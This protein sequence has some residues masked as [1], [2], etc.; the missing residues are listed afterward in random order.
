MLSDLIDELIEIH[1]DIGD[2]PVVTA[3][4]EFEVP[5]SEVFLEVLEIDQGSIYLES[6]E[7]GESWKSISSLKN[8]AFN[9]VLHLVSNYPEFGSPDIKI[10]GETLPTLV[11]T[12]DE[13][14]DEE[15]HQG[16]SGGPGVQCV[17]Q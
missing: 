11:D 7:K 8:R 17:Q 6:D 13:N 1:N 14:D 16:G 9:K 15:Q 2:V 12:D 5:S 4:N 10:N 3:S